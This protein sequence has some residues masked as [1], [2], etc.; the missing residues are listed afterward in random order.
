MSCAVFGFVIRL[1]RGEKFRRQQEC[2]AEQ[3]KRPYCRDGR[4]EK[5]TAGSVSWLLRTLLLVR[6]GDMTSAPP[7]AKHWRRP[8]QLGRSFCA[9]LASS[10]S[11]F[12]AVHESRFGT[13]ALR[14]SPR[15]SEIGAIADVP[16]ASP[17]AIMTPST[18]SVVPLD[19]LSSR[20]IPLARRV[21]AGRPVPPAGY[22]PPFDQ[23]LT[24]GP[25]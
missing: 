16:T 21:M 4:Q 6:D 8:L 24:S 15:I 3:T 11:P 25:F 14:H 9:Y 17:M 7:L 5:H 20:I 12:V 2:E 1:C 10:A 13:A 23:P 22:R 19:V 18:I